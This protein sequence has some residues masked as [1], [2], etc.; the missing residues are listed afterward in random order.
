M[1]EL[2]SF[3]FSLKTGKMV[4]RAI[5]LFLFCVPQFLLAQQFDKGYKERGKASFY[6]EDL[7]GKQTANG[8]KYDMYSMT[9]AHAS[10]P[11]NSIIKVTNLDSPDKWVTLRINDRPLTPTRVLDISKRAA[12]KLGMLKTGELTVELEILKVGDNQV[13]TTNSD[14]LKNKAEADKK[15]AATP[16]EKPKETQKTQKNTPTKKG[17]VAASA[18]AVSTLPLEERFLQPGTYNVWGTKI[19]PSGFG[20]QIGYFTDINK[21]IEVGREAIDLGLKEL[22]IQSD[23]SG[24]NAT[25]RIIYGSKKD[26]ESAKEQLPIA[27][28]KGFPEAFVK[29]F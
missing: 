9:A 8:E 16:S 1:K 5:F 2:I 3:Q 27:K 11:F 20:L 15:I 7:D 13:V 22:Y 28:M 18:A 10:I 19:T 4:I 21:A 26:E 25:Y 14:S 29:K 23:N 12:L 24:G 6:G 17:E